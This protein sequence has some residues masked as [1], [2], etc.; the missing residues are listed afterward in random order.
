MGHTTVSL[1]SFLLIFFPLSSFYNN[2]HYPSDGLLLLIVNVHILKSLLISLQN[3]AKNIGGNIEVIKEPLNGHGIIKFNGIHM[4]EEL[5]VEFSYEIYR[6]A[7]LILEEKF[8]F[9][10][11]SKMKSE[12][13]DAKV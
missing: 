4:L 9:H 13:T 10:E 8:R 11:E 5:E 12:V 7:I 2:Q 6:L 1:L 3:Y